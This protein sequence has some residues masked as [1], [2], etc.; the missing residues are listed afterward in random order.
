[1]T[2]QKT[3]SANPEQNSRHFVLWQHVLLWGVPLLFGLLGLAMGKVA[4]WDFLNYHW[5]NP[6]ALLHG[7]M[8]MDMAV[9]HHATFYNPL[10]DIPFYLAAQNLPA[11]LAGFLLATVQGVNFSLLCLLAHAVLPLA[12]DRHRFG[13]AVVVALAGMGGAGAFGQIGESAG[14]NL[15]SLGVIAMLLVLA[16]QWPRLSTGTA[17]TVML[18]AAAAGLLGG[19][20]AGSKLTM[21]VYVAG[22]GSML[23]FLPGTFPRRL[24]LL[25]AFGMGGAAGFALTAGPWMLRMGH[26][27]GNPLFPYFNDFFHSPLLADSSF[28][29]TRFL[30]KTLGDRLLFPLWFS[31]NSLRVAE[32]YFRDIHILVFYLL[33][34]VALLV[35]LLRRGHSRDGAADPFHTFLFLGGLFSY[36]LWLQM[37]SIYRYLIVL[38]MLSPLLIT[39]ALHRLTRSPRIW[40]PASGLVLLACQLAVSVEVDRKPWDD[41]FVQV[42]V[43]PITNPAKTMVL[44]AGY[45][46]MAYV[47]PS[48]PPQIPFIRI[49]G[50]LAGP[51]PEENDYIREMRRRVAAFQ[52]DL[53]ILF[54]P[55]EE[56]R[57]LQA[58]NA[59]GLDIDR[60]QCREVTSNIGPNLKLCRVVAEPAQPR[61]QIH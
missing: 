36:L 33:S 14:D 27:T 10:L 53:L 15:A 35:P 23:L 45:E 51:G 30:P 9:A 8:D 21:A 26:L 18:A 25:A 60:G 48:F 2:F 16:R 37:F 54:R 32:Y 20:A 31:L 38:E 12:N 43:P 44:M 46:P 57:S 39:L 3:N 41:R 52:G 6:H 47:I 24:L 40:L 56:E 4:S 58:V 42:N 28:R 34:P 29:D 22:F 19:L 1:M 49:Q 59:F 5:Y 11:W 55:R 61:G 17:R 13:A 50:Y 7:R